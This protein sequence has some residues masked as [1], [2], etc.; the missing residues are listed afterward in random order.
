[1]IL[2]NAVRLRRLGSDRKITFMATL[3]V[4]FLIACCRAL[5]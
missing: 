4:F 2:A 3:V 5:G 1:M